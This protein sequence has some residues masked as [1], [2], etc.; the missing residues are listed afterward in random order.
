MRAFAQRL[1]PGEAHLGLPPFAVFLVRPKIKLDHIFGIQA[2]HCGKWFSHLAAKAVQ[3]T[4]LLF[5]NE[6]FHFRILEHA[7][8]HRLAHVKWT[9]LRDA[10]EFPVS[11]MHLAAAL[12]TTLLQDAKVAGNGVVLDIVWRA[13]TICRVNSAICPS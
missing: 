2:Q 9:A 12:G 11:F 1:H 13:S 6:L 5:A 10:L 8:R 4:D 3:R 7:T